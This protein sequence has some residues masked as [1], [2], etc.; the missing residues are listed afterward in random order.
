MCRYMPQTSFMWKLWSQMYAPMSQRRVWSLF[1]KFDFTLLIRRMT[2]IIFFRRWSKSHVNVEI[3]PKSFNAPKSCYVSWNVNEPK[4][5]KITRAIENVALNVCL[6]IK[7][8]LSLCHV[9]S[10]NACHFVTTGIVIHAQWSKR[11]DADVERLPFLSFVVGQK[12]INRLN[13][14]NFVSF[15]RSVITR[16]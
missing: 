5:A 10:T 1:S 12:R 2:I 16:W 9:E 8:V 14:R 15:L 6:A 11:F 13:V 3:S 4:T 7:Y